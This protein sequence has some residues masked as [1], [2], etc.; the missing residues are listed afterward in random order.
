MTEK[1][2]VVAAGAG[3]RQNAIQGE[4]KEPPG[5]VPGGSILRGRL[6]DLGAAAR[7]G[8]RRLDHTLLREPVREQPEH[9]PAEGR[10]R[11]SLRER[12]PVET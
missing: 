5:P 7:T 9:D 11:D 10:A 3:E 12:V 1:R 2:P 6:N 8:A 4:Q